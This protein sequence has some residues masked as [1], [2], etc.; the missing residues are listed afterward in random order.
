MKTQRTG[1][2]PAA[3]CDLED[4]LSESLQFL[5]GLDDLRE[6]HGEIV[7]ICAFAQISDQLARVGVEEDQRVAIARLGKDRE[8]ERAVDLFEALI[9][10]VPV[11]G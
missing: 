4:I 11:P 1:W 5:R 2:L 3:P 6:S 8:Y 9:F 10:P 7:L